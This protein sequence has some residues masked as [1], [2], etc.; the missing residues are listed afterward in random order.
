MGRCRQ[1]VKLKYLS[2]NKMQ[3]VFLLIGLWLLGTAIGFGQ[4]QRKDLAKASVKKDIQGSLFIIG[5]GHKDQHLM[6][7]MVD[8]AA[9]K[10]QD[11]IAILPMASGYAEE[12]A[13]DMRR[14]L[15]LVTKNKVWSKNFSRAQASQESLVDSIRGA[16]LIYITGGDQNRFMEVVRGTPLFEAI[17]KAFAQGACIAGTS[18]GAAMMS[19]YMLSGNQLIDTAYQSTFSSLRHNN[20]ELVAGLGL[21]KG[22]IVDQHF[23]KRSRYNRLFSALAAQPTLVCIGID[24][25]TAILVKGKHVQVLGEAQVVVASDFEGLSK[26]EDDKITFDNV[27]LRV[28]A[29]PKE[30][31]L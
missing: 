3:K 26:K 9:L 16:K 17:H 27:R 13:A 5:G 1:L 4:Q 22:A 8:A 18:A 15:A 31:S 21:L 12:S 25:S 19:E 24:E 29:A 7:D 2:I 28:Y 6:Q 14:Q 20:V 23:I 30:F 11:Y 10:P